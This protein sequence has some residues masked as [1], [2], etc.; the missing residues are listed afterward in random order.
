MPSEQGVA[1]SLIR[2]R[3]IYNRNWSCLF[4]IDGRAI[5][6]ILKFL[7]QHTFSPKKNFAPGLETCEKKLYFCSISCLVISILSFMSS[8]SGKASKQETK[9]IINI[10]IINAV[11][12]DCINEKVRILVLQ[13]KDRRYSKSASAPIW[14]CWQGSDEL[15]GECKWMQVLPTSIPHTLSCMLYSRPSSFS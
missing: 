9:N 11:N 10:R 13:T 4:Y 7:I 8:G 12:M 14:P 1:N 2:D 6:L 15:W 5:T 3:N